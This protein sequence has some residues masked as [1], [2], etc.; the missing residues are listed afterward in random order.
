MFSFFVLGFTEIIPTED[1][2]VFTPHELLL[3]L[4]GKSVVVTAEMQVACRYTGG[5]DKD[6]ETIQLFWVTFDLL[7]QEQRRAVLKFATGA[8]R[9]PLDGFDPT[10]T[11]TRSEFDRHALP[12]S[13]TCFN[14]LVLPPY[15]DPMVLK[16][17]LLLSCSVEGFQLT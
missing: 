15:T 11:L 12:T 7:T 6:S 2:S 13:H 17:K 14:Q 10:F 3:L 1:V 8:S 16:E 4:N 9:V 5:Y